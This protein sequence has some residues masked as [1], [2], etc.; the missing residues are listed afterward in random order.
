M[1]SSASPLCHSLKLW[2]VLLC[3][4]G[5][6]SK[7]RK[8]AHHCHEIMNYSGSQPVLSAFTWGPHGPL[9]LVQLECE[10]GPE[11]LPTINNHRGHIP[12]SGLSEDYESVNLELME[13]W[14]FKFQN[15]KIAETVGQGLQQ[16]TLTPT[17]SL[18]LATSPEFQCL[19]LLCWAWRSC[20][21]RYFLFFPQSVKAHIICRLKSQ[22][23]IL[24]GFLIVWSEHSL[25]FRNLWKWPLHSISPHLCLRNHWNDQYLIQKLLFW[26]THKIYMIGMVP[27]S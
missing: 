24:F 5:P 11:V 25:P 4:L 10:S 21:S 26:R 14:C 27:L 23:E 12:E 6:A 15:S 1:K 2:D 13:T 16:L 22:D 9:L 18:A 20:S 19:L 8:S 7:K 3:L 17:C